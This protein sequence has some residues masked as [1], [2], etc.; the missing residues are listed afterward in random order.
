MTPSPGKYTFCQV[1]FKHQSAD[2]SF[3]YAKFFSFLL[4]LL[5]FDIVSC[6]NTVLLLLFAN[7]SF[8]GGDFNCF[9]DSEPMALLKKS[10]TLLGPVKFSFPS[11]AQEPDVKYFHSR[12]NYRIFVV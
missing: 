7:V 2:F 12:K 1:V 9:P 3:S 5:F 8:L 4:F 10:W 11:H 6:R